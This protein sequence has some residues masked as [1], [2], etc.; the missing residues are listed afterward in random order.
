MNKLK[1]RIEEM[2]YIGLTGRIEDDYGK[3]YA[4][5]YR[6]AFKTIKKELLEYTVSNKNYDLQLMTF[7]LADKHKI[8]YSKDSVNK[9]ILNGFVEYIKYLSGLYAMYKDV[10]KFYEDVSE[11]VFYEDVFEKGYTLDDIENLYTY[12]ERYHVLSVCS[13]YGVI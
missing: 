7:S 6:Y 10:E 9:E 3:E 4:R 11:E 5:T 2:F 12:N 1:L 13:N 8:P